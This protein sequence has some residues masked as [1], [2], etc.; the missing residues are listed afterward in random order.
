MFQL[1]APSTPNGTWVAATF[2]VQATPKRQRRAVDSGDGEVFTTP[3]PGMLAFKVN[4]STGEVSVASG[5][6]YETVPWYSFAV[7]I[8]AGGDE[9][10]KYLP[11]TAVVP[12]NISIGPVACLRGTWSPTGTYP[13]ADHSPRC[14]V[15]FN[16]TAA[17][18]PTND[19]Q[20]S[21]LAKARADEKDSNANVT[22]AIAVLLVI[23]ALSLVVFGRI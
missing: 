14:T 4:E 18:T 8:Q 5:L 22:A 15:G 2:V 12:L 9:A 6:D 10:G 23:A 19:R 17:P 21:Q 11:Y 1:Q 7:I 20:C 3:D 13:C 16:E